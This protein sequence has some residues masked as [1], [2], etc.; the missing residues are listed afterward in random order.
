MMTALPSVGVASGVLNTNTLK[1][2][3]TNSISYKNIKNM[4]ENNPHGV[5]GKEWDRHISSITEDITVN[6]VVY[7]TSNFIWNWLE[8]DNL[9]GR[10]IDVTEKTIHAFCGMYEF[11]LELQ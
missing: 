7:N 6:K 5:K 9:N 2:R 10:A 8:Q 1:A 4:F 11:I 3:A